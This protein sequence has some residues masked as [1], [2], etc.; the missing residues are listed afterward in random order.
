[1]LKRY[2]EAGV[3]ISVVPS[4]VVN[5]ADRLAV[6]SLD[7]DFPAYSFGVFTVRGP[8]ADPC[9]PTFPRGAHCRSPSA[10]ETRAALRLCSRPGAT[11]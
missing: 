2:V 9:R 3:G 1:M 8:H 5:D 6:V 10:R 11:G 7:A 4:L